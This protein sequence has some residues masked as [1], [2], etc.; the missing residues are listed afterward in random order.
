MVKDKNFIDWE[1]YRRILSIF[2]LV[3][4]GF[5]IRVLEGVIPSPIIFWTGVLLLLNIKKIQRLPI[6]CWCML[7]F[8]AALYT[9][10]SYIKGLQPQEF[11]YAAWL[12]A[13]CVLSNYWIRSD[14]LTVDLY[15]FTKFCFYYNIAHLLAL[16]F[17]NSLLIVTDFGMRPSTI[18]YIFYY[19]V[20][21]GILGI[22]RIQGFCWEPSC[23]NSLL[24]LNVALTLS[25]R[26]PWK[27]L[28]LP[29]IS[30]VSVFSTTGFA[31]LL[32]IIGTYFLVYNRKVSWTYKIIIVL[33][34]AI[35]FPIAQKDLSDKLKEGSG[36]TRLGDFY[37]AS[38]IIKQSPFLGDDIDN[39]TKNLNAMKEKEKNWGINDNVDRF[40]E[41][42]MTNAFAGLFVEYGLIIPVLLFWLFYVSPIFPNRGTAILVEVCVLVVLMGTPIARTG[43]FYMF[44]FS[45]LILFKKRKPKK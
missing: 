1:K 3:F 34:A 9:L 28:I 8:I 41:V 20:R 12:S 7:V 35:V 2:L 13:F 6:Y 38:Y 24:N 31:T 22:P 44:P 25:M 36:A 42:G 18:L 33:F 21:E 17:F 26:K 15:V 16:L 23:W 30:I 5:G 11:Y 27:E 45:T 29:I 43:F 39:I 4:E 32:I 14:W 19:N 40:S 37:V 10:F